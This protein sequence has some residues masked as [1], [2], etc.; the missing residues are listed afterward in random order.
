MLDPSPMQSLAIERPEVEAASM[1]QNST[2]NSANSLDP[3]IKARVNDQTNN[4]VAFNDVVTRLKKKFT[5]KIF[6]R[7]ARCET[8]QCYRSVGVDF[9]A[10]VGAKLNFRV[11]E[12]QKSLNVSSQSQIFSSLGTHRPGMISPRR[13]RRPMEVCNVEEKFTQFAS[14]LRDAREI[15]WGMTSKNQFWHQN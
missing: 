7:T 13:Q 9:G 12:A 10:N 11:K 14:K 8:K 6:G 1:L 15:C 3:V 2:A 4:F 5:K